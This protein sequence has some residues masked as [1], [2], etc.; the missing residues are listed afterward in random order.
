[1]LIRKSSDRNRT[2]KPKKKK[3]KKN[4]HATHRGSAAQVLAMVA[5][6]LGLH[7]VLAGNRSTKKELLWSI[8]LRTASEKQ[9]MW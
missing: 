3:K 4:Q 9:E 7:P 2:P 1:M 8:A 6:V 5:V